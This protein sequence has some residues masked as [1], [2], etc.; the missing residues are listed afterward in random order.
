MCVAP[1]SNL[2]LPRCRGYGP[3]PRSCRAILADHCRAVRADH[4]LPV[5]LLSAAYLP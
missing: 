3:L 5:A 2:A 1:E 4:S